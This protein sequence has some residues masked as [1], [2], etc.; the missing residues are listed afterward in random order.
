MNQ[1]MSVKEWEGR[2]R[3][4]AAFG[5]YKDKN[6]TNQKP[7]KTSKFSVKFNNVT[8]CKKI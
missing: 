3:Q 7:R 2:V 1:A 4:Y 6:D 5:G 8:K